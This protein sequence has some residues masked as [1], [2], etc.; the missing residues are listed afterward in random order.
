MYMYVLIYLCI[1]MYMYVLIYRLLLYL[2]LFGFTL[3]PRPYR[4]RFKPPLKFLQHISMAGRM[5]VDLYN[6]TH[7]TQGTT[8]DQR[9][10]DN[11]ILMDRNMN[12]LLLPATPNEIRNEVDILISDLIVR[13]KQLMFN[14]LLCAYYVG[15]IP[16]L[17]AEVSTH[18]IIMLVIIVHI[19]LLHITQH[20]MYSWTYLYI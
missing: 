3:D 2:S 11:S 15:F 17:F 4:D 14:S 1:I 6:Y 9:N 8:H 18:T 12:A 20:I 10:T 19:I 5:R 16:M 13:L 7:T